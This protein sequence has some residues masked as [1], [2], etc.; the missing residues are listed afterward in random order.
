META[1]V[2]H[3]SLRSAASP[4]VVR[5]RFRALF[6]AECSYVC[7]TL[8]RLGV[9]SGDVDDVAQEVFLVVHRQLD[10]GSIDLGRPM[11]PW[12]FG[13]A[14]RTVANYR[15]LARHRRERLEDDEAREVPDPSAGALDALEAR[16][17]R[18]QVLA[19][20]DTLDLDRRAVLVMHDLDECP[21]PQIATALAIP[22]NTAY[23]RLRL[24]RQDFAR[25]VQRLAART[26]G[27]T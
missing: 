23:S 12:L 2:D 26:G 10:S 11:R 6:D 9:R 25:A 19:A 3:T 20:L 4:A 17:A 13:I 14:V 27:T 18:E 8:R 21:V 22:L 24:A 7:H 16:R 1:H 5:E 15:R